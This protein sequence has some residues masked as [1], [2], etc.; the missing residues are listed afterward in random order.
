MQCCFPF[1]LSVDNYYKH[2]LYSCAYKVYQIIYPK[3]LQVPRQ[4]FALTYG[5]GLD[6]KG[7]HFYNTAD[8]YL[9]PGKNKTRYI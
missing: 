1:V 2:Y 7:Q 6:S 9:T 4:Y 5:S 3:T 8:K